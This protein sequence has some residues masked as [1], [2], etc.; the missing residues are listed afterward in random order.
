M[1]FLC[2]KCP[3]A[4]Q[5]DLRRQ[6]RLPRILPLGRLEDLQDPQDHLPLLCGARRAYPVS[7]PRLRAWKPWMRRVWRGMYVCMPKKGV[8]VMYTS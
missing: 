1:P 2:L 5:E 3:E 4:L 8:S 7:E 6:P